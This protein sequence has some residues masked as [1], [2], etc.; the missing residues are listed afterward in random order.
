MQ[1]RERAALLVGFVPFEKPE[2]HMSV[3]SCGFGILFVYADVIHR[4]FVYKMPYH[5]FAVASTSNVGM[6]EKHFQF[7]VHDAR[8]TDC[9]TVLVFEYGYKGHSGDC[10]GNISRDVFDVGSG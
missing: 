8:K 9:F 1:N 3:K 10:F 7:V 6:Q 5:L 4:V 2:S